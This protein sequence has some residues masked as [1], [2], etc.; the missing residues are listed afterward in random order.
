MWSVWSLLLD[1]SLQVGFARLLEIRK[2]VGQ[3]SVQHPRLSVK[4][5]SAA[6]CEAV[7]RPLLLEGDTL[8]EDLSAPP[9]LV[10][11]ALLGCKVEAE[12]L[13]PGDAYSGATF[14]IG[15]LAEGHG[16][17][18]LRSMVLTESMFGADAMESGGNVPFESMKVA[19]LKEE[20]AARGSTRRTGLKMVLQRR[21]HAM[22]M[23]SAIERQARQ[24]ED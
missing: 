12:P 23:Q 7:L 24:M 22:L 10:S 20:L 3:A 19:Q 18:P 11:L 16:G 2:G 8:R 1:G 5:E 14:R 6:G 17:D 9:K 21:L 13:A 4:R 15:A